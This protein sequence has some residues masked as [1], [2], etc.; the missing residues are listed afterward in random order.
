MG[1]GSSILCANL[2]FHPLKTRG[3]RG[4]L[5]AILDTVAGQTRRWWTWHGNLRTFVRISRPFCVPFAKE[6]RVPLCKS[7][8]FYRTGAGP[9]SQKHRVFTGGRF[10]TR[11]F[12]VGSATSP[13]PG[14]GSRPDTGF[15][16]HS[17][18]DS[19]VWG[20]PRARRHHRPGRPP[21]NT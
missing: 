11:P 4:G 13:G 3:F 15:L 17:I 2:G 6:W 16:A 19:T 5:V 14:G 21:G 1:G 7:T 20:R 18:E 8:V 12:L 10:L 9:G